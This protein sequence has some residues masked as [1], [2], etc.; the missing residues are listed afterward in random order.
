ME[1][2]IPDHDHAIDVRAFGRMS[3]TEFHRSIA[4]GDR[5]VIF[6]WTLSAI[7]ISVTRHTRVYRCRGR[8]GSILKGLPF[9]IV[10]LLFG[11]WS[12]PG[13]LWNFRSVYWNM[14]GGQDVS[15]PVLEV[16]RYQDPRYQYGLR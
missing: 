1:I 3:E 15:A 9:L 13:G 6:Y 5:Y 10:C 8:K 7:F 4:D 14:I 16:I 12:I 2:P 11:W